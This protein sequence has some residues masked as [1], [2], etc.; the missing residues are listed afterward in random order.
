MS[1]DF[2][3]LA[4][5]ALAVLSASIQAVIGMRR[6]QRRLLSAALLWAC[7]ATGCFLQAFAPNLKVER[8][9]FV[10]PAADSANEPVDP[11]WVVEREKQM[12]ALSLVFL[13]IAGVGL[14]F[15]YRGELFGVSRSTSEDPPCD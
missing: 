1:V 5:G 15:Q 9:A 10:M 6:R 12:K 7:L 11:R 2:V 4:A 13:G 8:N 3:F 14:C